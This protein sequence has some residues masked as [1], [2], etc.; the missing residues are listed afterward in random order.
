[1]HH[2]IESV[3]EELSIAISYSLENFSMVG[4]TYETVV[5]SYTHDDL[6]TITHFSPFE[7]S[8]QKT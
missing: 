3:T 6:E 1:M 2:E 7:T 8:L 4:H 5:V